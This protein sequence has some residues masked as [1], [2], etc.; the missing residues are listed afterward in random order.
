MIAAEPCK[1]SNGSYRAFFETKEAAEAFAA[2]PANTAYHGDLAHHCRLCGH[3]HLSRPEWL[4]LEWMRD[5]RHSEW[6]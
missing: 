5:M 1:R 4:V 2:D 3:W 6:N